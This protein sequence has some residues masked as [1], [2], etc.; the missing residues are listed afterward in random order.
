MAKMEKYGGNP[1]C[2]IADP[3][4]FTVPIEDSLDFLTNDEGYMVMLVLT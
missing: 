2:I 3:E 1:R 4:I